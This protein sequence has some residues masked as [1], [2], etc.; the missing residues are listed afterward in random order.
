MQLLIPSF[1][2]GVRFGARRASIVLE[3]FNVL[4]T[5]NEVEEVAVVTHGNFRATTAVEPP[6]AIRVDIRGRKQVTLVV[7]AGQGLDLADHAD[8]CDVRFIQNTSKSK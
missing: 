4:N 5:A 2:K 3:A 1:T 8:W 7:E 6:R